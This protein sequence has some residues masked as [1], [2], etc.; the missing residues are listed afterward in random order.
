[1]ALTARVNLT[2]KT[3][4]LE[5]CSKITVE[6]ITGT[7]NATTNPLGYGLPGGIAYNDITKII[8]SVYY[9]NITTPIIYTFTYA[10]GTVTALTV[11]D[12]NGVV[13]NIFADLATLMVDGVFDL[14][15]TDAFI[16]PV[17]VDGIFN[18]EFNESGTHSEEAF[19]YTTNNS[20]LSSCKT[21]CCIEK[22][23]LNLDPNCDCC[24]HKIEAIEQA[25]VFL[26]AAKFSINVG[27]DSKAEEDLLKAKEICSNNCKTC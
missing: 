3:C 23:Y 25:E 7:Y 2:I 8:I 10:T 22:M 13:Y 12:L 6:D 15:G 19:S 17:I 18:V 5:G 21:E 4:L 20:F 11:T 1:M 14:T 9:P 16:L 24:D 26:Q 27:Q